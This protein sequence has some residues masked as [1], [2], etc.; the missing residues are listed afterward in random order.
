[1]ANEIAGPDGIPYMQFTISA[2]ELITQRAGYSPSMMGPSIFRE[3]DRQERLTGERFPDQEIDYIIKVTIPITNALYKPKT[4]IVPYIPVLNIIGPDA[5]HVGMTKLPFPLC[6][7]LI[8]LLVTI[9]GP[10]GIL[11][12]RV[13]TYPTH[14]FK[15]V[16]IGPRKVGMYLTL[17]LIN[18]RADCTGK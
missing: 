17:E 4:L 9:V 7:K 5:L 15:E 2:H 6:A 8:I 14:S 13:K 11:Y 10:V 1:M 18:I 16:V 3:P 12:S